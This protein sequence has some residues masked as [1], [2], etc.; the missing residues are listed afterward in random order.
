MSKEYKG[1][2]NN[3]RNNSTN[4][5]NIYIY[6]NL[7][8]DNNFVKNSKNDLQQSNNS[9]ILSIIKLLSLLF[10]PFFLF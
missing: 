7:F 8:I 10:Y 9:F 3:K 2:K 6:Y 4:N 1:K 5:M